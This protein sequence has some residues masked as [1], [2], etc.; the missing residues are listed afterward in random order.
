MRLKMVAER[1]P[2]LGGALTQVD[3]VGANLGMNDNGN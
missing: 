2:V 3:R 1:H